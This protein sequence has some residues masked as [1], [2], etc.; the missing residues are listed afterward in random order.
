LASPHLVEGV[1]CEAQPCWKFVGILHQPV[2][3]HMEN[4]PALS[5]ISLFLPES[6]KIGYAGATNT[7]VKLLCV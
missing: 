1:M 3:E 7:L 5:F 2:A 6:T 4:F